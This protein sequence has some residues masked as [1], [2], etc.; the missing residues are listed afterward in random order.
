MAG[1]SLVNLNDLPEEALH[2]LI[3]ASW[4]HWSDIS[5]MDDPTPEA[6]R[7]YLRHEGPAIPRLHFAAVQG[8]KAVGMASIAEQDFP[9]TPGY[10]PWLINLFI[11]PQHRGK[12]LGALLKA[13]RLQKLRQL[14]YTRVYLLAAPATAPLHERAGFGMLHPET[15]IMYRKL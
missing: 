4:Q 7:E 15:H 2:E 13:H 3:H 12:G 10:S 1:Y 6:W 9:P 8:G 5:H 11:M 14:G